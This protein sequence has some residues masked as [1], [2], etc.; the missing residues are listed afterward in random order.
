MPATCDSGGYAALSYTSVGVVTNYG[1]FGREFDLVT[2]NPVASR[3]TQKLKGAFNEGAIALQLGLDTDDAGQ[4]LM[5]S[6]SLSDSLYAFLITTAN[7]DKYYFQGLTMG[8]KVGLNDVNSVSS[9]TANIEITTSS[10]G[11]GIVEVLA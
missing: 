6:A 1:E 10:T 11:V 4:I 8:F 5:K 2:H 3:G 7:G 9:A